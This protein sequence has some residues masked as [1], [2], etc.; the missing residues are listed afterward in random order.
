MHQTAG[1]SATGLLSIDCPDRPLASPVK[2]KIGRLPMTI[3]ES[4]RALL[5]DPQDRVLL[6]KLAIDAQQTYWLTPGGS[7]HA[8]ESFEDALRREIREETGLTLAQPGHWVWT[9]PKRIVRDGRPVDTLARV[10]IQRVPNF[11][12]TPTALTSAE[13]RMFRELRWWSIDEIAASREAFIP[14]TLAML[15]A[16]LLEG[17]W[18]AEP[19]VIVP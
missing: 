1:Y 17:P 16:A 10:Y 5:V 8:G 12:A 14:R 4:A 15:L 18:P 6:M 2:C 19:I 9:S 11:S 3:I 13:R 7:L